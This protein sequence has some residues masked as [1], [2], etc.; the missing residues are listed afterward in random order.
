MVRL[1]A[2]SGI[3][4]GLRKVQQLIEAN[5]RY[6]GYGVYIAPKAA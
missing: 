1:V 2:R 5:S 6:F 4:R 3:R